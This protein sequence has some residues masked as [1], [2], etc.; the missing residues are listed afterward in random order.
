[1]YFIVLWKKHLN[2][3][4]FSTF[5]KGG[6]KTLFQKVEPKLSTFILILLLPFPPFPPLGKVEPNSIILILLLP[7]R[8]VEPNPIILILLLPLRKVETKPFQKVDFTFYKV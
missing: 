6:A 7:L 3:S 2:P 5:R 8:K 4:T 1:M